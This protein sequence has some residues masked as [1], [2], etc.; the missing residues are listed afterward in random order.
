MSWGQGQVKGFVAG[1]RS[2]AGSRLSEPGDLVDLD[3]EVRRVGDGGRPLLAIYVQPH[4]DRRIPQGV[5]TFTA[6][7]LPNSEERQDLMRYPDGDDPAGD[8]FPT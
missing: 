1:R 8:W 4:V 5:S 6:L 7:D 3:G 2:W